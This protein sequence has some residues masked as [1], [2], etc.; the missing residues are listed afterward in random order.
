MTPTID[1]DA[2][3]RQAGAVNVQP[4][5][6]STQST[7]AAPQPN[8]AGPTGPTGP[9]DY[10]ALAK[11]AGAVD[12]QPLASAPQGEIKNDVGNTVIVPKEDESFADT[13]KRAAAQGRK[14]TPEQINAEL[15][16][17]PG[18]A[19]TVLAAAPVIGAAGVTA[20]MTPEALGAAK[21]AILKHLAE[22]SPELFGHEAVKETLKNYAMEGA[23]K[24]LTGAAW[25]GGAE[26]LHSIWDDVFGKKR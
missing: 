3:A 22:Q 26:L 5:T 20:A 16:T 8:P 13:M 18:K 2:L 25:A 21:N 6:P 12:V 23:K 19:A 4:A 17:A 24:A 9:V 1:Y 11:Q 10:D 14:T 7:Q 15:R